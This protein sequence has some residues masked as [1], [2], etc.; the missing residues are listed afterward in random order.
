MIFSLLSWQ[1]CYCVGI[2]LRLPSLRYDGV[3]NCAGSLLTS[4]HLLT[5][6]HC[7]RSKKKTELW[8]VHIPGN[9]HSKQMDIGVSLTSYEKYDT[10][11][12][13]RMRSLDQICNI[14][15]YLYIFV[16]RQKILKTKLNK[17]I[18][19]IKLSG[20]ALEDNPGAETL[21]FSLPTSLFNAVVLRTLGVLRLQH[22]VRAAPEQTD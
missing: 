4:R 8:R 12:S 11:V 20:R 17:T 19:T 3:H 5:A 13:K 15:Q 18:K 1:Q 22:A 7:F 21:S 9:P 16:S 2:C 14:I 10:T 6:A